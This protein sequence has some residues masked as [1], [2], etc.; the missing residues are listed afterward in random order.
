MGTRY[1]GTPQEVRAL[2]CYIK[3]MRCANSVQARLERQLAKLGLTESQ[4]GILEALLHLGSVP[5]RELGRA[6]FKSR[7]N[8]TTVV[9]NLE[10]RGLVRRQR[11]SADRRFVMVH[12][13][14]AGRTLVERVFPLQLRAIVHEFSV[15]TAD[16]QDELGR[17]T[18]RLG[19]QLGARSAS[20]VPPRSH[21]SSAP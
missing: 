15:L 12:L 9:D 8:V 6:I 3:L 2:D 14:A 19:L 20:Q 1:R 21:S 4:F 5:Q 17:L 11:E 18:K 10:R 13:T 7:A 16:E